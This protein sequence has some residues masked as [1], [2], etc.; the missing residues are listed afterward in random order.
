MSNAPPHRRFP[1]TVSK[2][3]DAPSTTRPL[4]SDSERGQETWQL[5][6]FAEFHRQSAVMENQKAAYFARESITYID[7]V[8]LLPTSTPKR[9]GVDGKPNVSVGNCKVQTKNTCTE[10]LNHGTLVHMPYSTPHHIYMRSSC[11]LIVRIHRV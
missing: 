2:P 9:T 10:C 8:L 4:F 7:R 1:S 3:L 6:I 11:R 5:L